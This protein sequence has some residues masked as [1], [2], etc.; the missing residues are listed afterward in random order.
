MFLSQSPIGI[1]IIFLSKQR[2]GILQRCLLYY[3]S[4][5]TPTKFNWVAFYLL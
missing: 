3:R 4:F 5:W 1:Q 2:S